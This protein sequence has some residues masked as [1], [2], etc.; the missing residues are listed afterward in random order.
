MNTLPPIPTALITN[1]FFREGIWAAVHDN[2]DHGSHSI[3]PF[4]SHDAACEYC[5]AYNRLQ[6]LELW[7]RLSREQIAEQ[8]CDTVYQRYTPTLRAF[9]EGHAP[10]AFIET[11]LYHTI[12]MTRSTWQP[13]TKDL[14][15]VLFSWSESDVDANA[16][17]EKYGAK[18]EYEWRNIQSEQRKNRFRCWCD[19]LRKNIVPHKKDLR[20]DEPYLDWLDPKVREWIKNSPQGTGWYK[21]RCRIC[22]SEVWQLRLEGRYSDVF[23]W[24]TVPA[25]RQRLRRAEKTLTPENIEEWFEERA[26]IY[27]FGEPG[28]Y[29]TTIIE[30]L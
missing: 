23:S 20:D 22:S 1:E 17:A 8:F 26:G 19:D 29:T 13:L 18:L 14:A 9:T 24:Y 25:K 12:E 7:K 3:G 4:P 27:V 16:V 10:D 28:F 15:L 5:E 21:R 6:V 11:L 2:Y 30:M